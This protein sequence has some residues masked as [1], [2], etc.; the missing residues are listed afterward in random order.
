MFDVPADTAQNYHVEG[1]PFGTRG[2]ILIK[3]QFPADGQYTFTVKGV[4]GYFQAVLG[5]VTGEQLD[6]TVDGER[7]TLFDWDK[8]IAQHDRQRQGHAAREGPRGAAHG[9]RDVPGH[10]RR[11]RHRAR[12]AR[13]SAR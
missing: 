11:A 7:V 8:E 6:V 12:T 9:G 4:T 13:S 1:L 10:Q 3:H 2:G 5:G